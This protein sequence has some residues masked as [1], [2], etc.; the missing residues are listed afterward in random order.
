[1]SHSRVLAWHNART[2]PGCLLGISSCASEAE[3]INHCILPFNLQAASL[4]E[5]TAVHVW[6]EHILITEFWQI[7]SHHRQRAISE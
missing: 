1:M 7:S 6:W 5:H 4:E 3:P 2:Q